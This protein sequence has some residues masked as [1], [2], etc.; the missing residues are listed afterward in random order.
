[1]SEPLD[2]RTRP[3]IELAAPNPEIKGSERGTGLLWLINRVVFHPRGFAL[4]LDVDAATGDVRGWFLQG[5][6]SECW[7]FSEES[8]DRHFL[9]AEAFLRQQRVEES[10]E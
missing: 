4:A 10:A 3:L 1:M 9:E 6:G 2:P 8:D 5:D 7:T